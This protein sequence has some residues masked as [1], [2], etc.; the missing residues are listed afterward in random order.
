MLAAARLLQYRKPGEKI[1]GKDVAVQIGQPGKDS[2]SEVAHP[3]THDGT[4]NSN[5][6]QLS[7]IGDIETPEDVKSVM[8][9]AQEKPVR[10]SLTDTGERV[11]KK[12]AEAVYGMPLHNQDAYFKENNQASGKLKVD[13]EGATWYIPKTPALS[14]EVT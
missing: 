6:A 3:R 14:A 13:N 10:L 7:Q 4:I 9:N 2:V 5:I 8:E 11:S 12:N 1:T